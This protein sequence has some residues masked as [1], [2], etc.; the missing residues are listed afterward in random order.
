MPSFIAM[1]GQNR[2][3]ISGMLIKNDISDSLHLL[4][5]TIAEK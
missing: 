2:P 5:L 4:S 3:L 1:S